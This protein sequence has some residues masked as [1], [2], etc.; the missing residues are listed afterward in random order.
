MSEEAQR[1]LTLAARESDELSRIT[2]LRRAG[3]DAECARIVSIQVALQRQAR[4]KFDRA[5]QMLFTR[6]G[7]EQSTDHRI[8]AYKAQKFSAEQHVADICCGIGGDAAALSQTCP[9]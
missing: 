5:D 7:L 2:Q 1:W 6:R 9:L 4:R 3:L 8:A